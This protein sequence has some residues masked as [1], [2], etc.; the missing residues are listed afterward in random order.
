M[1]KVI[2]AAWEKGIQKPCF[3][4]DERAA[5]SLCER[6]WPGCRFGLTTIRSLFGELHGPYDPA[7]DAPVIAVVEGTPGDA[8]DAIV[9]PG[10][11]EQA[12]RLLALVIADIEGFGDVPYSPDVWPDAVLSKE[13]SSWIDFGKKLGHT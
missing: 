5:R 10:P 4:G 11:G 1:K 8:H 13:I 12:H 3:E 6:R 9:K 7:H 2:V